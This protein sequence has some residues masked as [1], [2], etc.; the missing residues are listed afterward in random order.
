MYSWVSMRRCAQGQPFLE[1]HVAWE[2]EKGM[3]GPLDSAPQQ[4]LQAQRG[5]LARQLA[6]PGSG[7]VLSITL[8]LNTA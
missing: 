4:P 8:L 6:L 7:S 5:L 2:A 1:D 3:G